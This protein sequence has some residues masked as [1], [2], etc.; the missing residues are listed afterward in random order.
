MN[1]IM[2]F[3][4][5]EILPS[6]PEGVQVEVLSQSEFNVT[7]DQPSQN[8]ASITEYAVN[9]TM[10]KS[11]DNNPIFGKNVQEQNS[12]RI[13]VT[14]HSVQVKVKLYNIFSRIYKYFLSKKWYMLKNL[15]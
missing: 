5:T 15:F 11:F 2:I 1:K 4:I 13:S 7:W 12:S 6:R 3:W 10:L 8:S 14:P 9:V